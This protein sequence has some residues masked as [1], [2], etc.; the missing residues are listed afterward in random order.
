MSAASLNDHVL[1]TLA[2]VPL[3]ERVL[4]LGECDETLASQ[5]FALGFDIEC[6]GWSDIESSA[7]GLEAER[8]GWIIAAIAGRSLSWW[9]SELEGVRPLL[10]S[11]GWAIVCAADVPDPT[12][13]LD[14]DS[15][16]RRGFE[17]SGFALA[18]GLVSVEG[19]CHVI[20]RRVDHG[21]EG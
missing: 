17:S 10:R 1:R 9:E 14:D 16:A 11:G 13:W 20:V 18:E 2:A 8:F 15:A 19:N 5:L 6:T 7:G 4:L 21:T 3:P 12:S